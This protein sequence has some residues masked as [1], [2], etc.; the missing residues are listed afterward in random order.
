[1]NI[2]I[3]V[4]GLP[5]EVLAGAEL[6]AQQVAEQ[7]ARRGH[8][9]TIFTRS[10][11]FYQSPVQQNG[12]TVT[13]RRVLPVKGARMIWDIAAALWDIAPTPLNGFLLP[14]RPSGGTIRY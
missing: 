10:R 14:A 7:L 11:G 12:Y 8:Q 1:M 6:Q 5:P 2:G 4:S 3:L 13:P 9:V